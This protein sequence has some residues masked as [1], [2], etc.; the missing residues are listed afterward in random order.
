MK[1]VLIIEDNENNLYLM[2]KIV[3]KMGYN[4]IEARDGATGVELAITEEPTIILLDIQLPVMD[5]YSVMKKIQENEITKNV[6]IIIVSSYAM[7][8]DKEKAFSAG[9]NEYVEKPIDPQSFIELLK[10]Y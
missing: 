5:G 9:C 3:Q 4:V 8:A 6:I 10:K 2:R 7:D 1:K